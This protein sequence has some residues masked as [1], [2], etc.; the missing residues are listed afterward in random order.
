MTL[1]TAMLLAGC[2][3]FLIR[4]SFIGMAGR[5]DIPDWFGRLLRFVPIAAL[6]ALVWPDLLLV[7]GELALGITNPRL[8]SGLIAAGV[9]WKTRNIFL[10]I[11][12]GMICLWVIQF[13]SSTWRASL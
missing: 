4:F 7:H 10:T 1:W 3:T 2:V 11:S 9:A 8:L 5:I 12:A 6:T 13:A